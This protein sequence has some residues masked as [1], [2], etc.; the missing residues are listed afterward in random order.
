MKKISLS[1]FLAMSILGSCTTL[2]ADELGFNAQITGASNYVLRG[3]T[4]SDDKAA[5]F[6]DFFLT[7]GNFFTGIWASNVSF[8]DIG[9]TDANIEVDYYAGYANAIN[10]FAFSAV[11]AKYTY[12]G[13]EMID[14][15]D[16]LKLD[17]SYTMDK[18]TIGGKYEMG[19]W[20][21]SDS[22][23]LDYIEGYASYNFGPANLNLSA[24]SFED[25]GDNYMIG[26]SKAGK[27]EDMDLEFNLNYV[28][29]ESDNKGYP[30]EDDDKI[31]AE[32]VFT[33]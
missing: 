5:V 15:L 20:N 16:E 31:Y 3:I 18:L 11:Y 17:L 19:I 1:A 23:K 29:F 10:N 9:V 32:V 28:N 13:S 26:V 24:G 33:F 6:G 7:Y 30:F 25:I 2:S 27:F 14:D 12:P 4:Q 22:D 8:E 21:E